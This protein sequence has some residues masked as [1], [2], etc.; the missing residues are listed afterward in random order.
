MSRW[1]IFYE[2]KENSKTCLP[3]EM[4]LGIEPWVFKVVKIYLVNLD[5]KVVLDEMLYYEVV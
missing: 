4:M 1:H 2:M 3:L 5:P